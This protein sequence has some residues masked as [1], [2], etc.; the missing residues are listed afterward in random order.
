MSR[1]LVPF[2]LLFVAA[3]GGETDTASTGSDLEGMVQVDGSST[4]YP[5]TEAVAEE[6]MKVYPRVRVTV[7]VSGTGG[8]FSKFL[9]GET[10]I[11]DA[12]RPIKPSEAELAI[13][14]NINYIELP[15]AFDGLAVVVN[16]AND[17]VECFEVNE[18]VATWQPGSQVNN[19]NQIRNGFPD[20]EL[21][22]Y[23]AGTDSGTYDYFTA[24][25]MGEEGASR[26]DFT[27]SEDDNVLVQGVAGDVG[28]MGFLPYAYYA[29][30]MDKLKLVGI[31]DGNPDNGAGCV[32]P[33]TET[34]QNA[35][36][37]PLARPEFIYVNAE[38]LDRPEVR[39]FVD[40][41]LQNAA[42][43]AKE[44]GYVGL[45][46]EAT[47]LTLARVDSRVTGSVFGGEGSQIGVR[48]EDLLQFDQ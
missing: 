1:Y 36:Y 19:W 43:L 37:Q 20:R 26:S 27:A 23:G 11:N 25:I 22:L 15:V 6:F 3:C 12:S 24:A 8:G 17:W 42:E 47:A 9:R 46:D 2:L 45:S 38:S 34:V 16:P 29:E 14:N 41:Y 5:L 40:Y 21:R 44:V 30:N 31:D 13:A 33:S 7:G 18:L 32:Q 10:D 39:A 4:V 35:T 48:I 28:A